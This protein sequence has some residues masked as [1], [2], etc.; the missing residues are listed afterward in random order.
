[1]IIIPA[2]LGRTID[3]VREQTQKLVGAT[4]TIHLDVMDGQFVPELTPLDIGSLIND[5]FVYDLH[6]MVIDPLQFIPV[7][8]RNQIQRVFVHA[9]L[10]EHTLHRFFEVAGD[11]PLRCGLAINPDTPLDIIDK[12][13]E[14]I[15][16]VLLMSVPPGESGRA[17][18]ENTVD[19]IRQIRKNYSQFQLQVDGGINE[20]TILKIKQADVCVA[21][22]V[23]FGHAETP[24]QRIKM[25]EILTKA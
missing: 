16:S 23:I 10:S 5:N 22:S 14:Q 2:V 4:Q 21:H 18:D 6:L 1:M 19:R 24:A 13:S 25:L 20:Q 17:F 15:D 12:Y 7:L 8:H 3:E 11:V 9:E